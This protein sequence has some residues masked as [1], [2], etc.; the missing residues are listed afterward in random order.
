M[1]RLPWAAGAGV[2]SHRAS[3]SARSRPRS[4]SRTPRPARCRRGN[5]VFRRFRLR[6]AGRRT[7]PRNFPKWRERGRVRQ[8]PSPL[9][10]PPRRRPRGSRR[11]A[12]PRAAP[13]PLAFVRPPGQARAPDS[14]AS[15]PL[16]AEAPAPAPTPGLNG[17]AGRRR[18]SPHTACR[19]AARTPRPT[20][21][22]H[23]AR[24]L[25]RRARRPLSPR[26]SVTGSGRRQLRR[27]RL[28]GCRRTPSGP[29]AASP[30]A[31][32]QRP[33]PTNDRKNHRGTPGAR[34]EGP[35]E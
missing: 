3:P 20:L 21:T 6:A 13:G 29:A 35:G 7:G 2:Q 5:S 25:A 22:R 12:A 31:C 14:A 23:S 30:R 26:L 1:A 19:G 27:R 28:R 18:H 8:P 34:E 15:L 9:W 32:A 16:T 17:G 4:A 10:L 33:L 11:S 24:R